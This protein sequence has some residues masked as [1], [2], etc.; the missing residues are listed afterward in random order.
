MGD[1]DVPN[2]FLEKYLNS[3]VKAISDYNRDICFATVNIMATTWSVRRALRN[4]IAPHSLFFMWIYTNLIIIKKNGFE[5]FRAQMR[6]WVWSGERK[7]TTVWKNLYSCKLLYVTLKLNKIADLDVTSMNS[8]ISL[9]LQNSMSSVFPTHSQYAHKQCLLTISNLW[10]C[11]LL[12]RLIL[13]L[14]TRIYF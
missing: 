5:F 10:K 14:Y 9:S 8:F 2:A 6:G 1:N 7:V 12:S 11:I 13:V 3:V 4:S